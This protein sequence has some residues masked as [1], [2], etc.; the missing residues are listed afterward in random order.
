MCYK[1][2]GQGN[3]MHKSGRVYLYICSMKRFGKLLPVFLFLAVYFFSCTT[4]DLYEKNVTIPG[5]KWKSS[6]QP[7]FDFEIKDSTSR[8]QPYF[9]LRHNEK[10]NYT[11]IW[12]NFYFKLP[13]DTALQKKP[14]EFLLATNDKGWLASGMDDIYEHRLPIDSTIY[15]RPGHYHFK[16]KQ[17]MREDPLENVLS[18]GIRLEKKL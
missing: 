10:Y 1:M 15:L 8:Y 17:I 9:V 14:I 2:Q 12:V 7:E 16:I 4:V 18:V 13:G 6:F 3:N 5:F 11:N